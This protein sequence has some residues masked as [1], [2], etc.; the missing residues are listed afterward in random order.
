MG[1]ESFLLSSSLVGLIAQR[2][3][4]RLC[5]TCKI[6]YLLTEDERV[7]MGVSDED[8]LSQ[9]PHLRVVSI[10]ITQDIVVERAFM[11]LS[12]LMKHLEV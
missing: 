7:L 6:P 2:L 4:R 5:D 1:V 9:Y 3:V 11:S 12:Q 10:A 8:D